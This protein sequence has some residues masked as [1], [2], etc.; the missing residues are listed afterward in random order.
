M[1]VVEEVKTHFMFNNFFPENCAIYEL[2]WKNM[3]E[4][5]RPQTT[6]QYGTCALHA[7]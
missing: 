4:V 7:G 1:N 5:D 3:A 2:M 6:I